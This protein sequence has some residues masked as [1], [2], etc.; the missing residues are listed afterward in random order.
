MKKIVLL[1]CIIGLRAFAQYSTPC[2]DYRVP[3]ILTDLGVVQSL[4]LTNWPIYT[5]TVAKAA[6]AVTTNDTRQLDFTGADILI[7]DATK[8]NHPVTKSQ[9]DANSGTTNATGINVAFT[10]TNYTPDS[11]SVEGHLIGIDAVVSSGSG[12]PLTNHGD[13]AGFNLTN[14]GLVQAVSGEFDYV[15]IGIQLRMTN[16]E[17]A[18]ALEVVDIMLDADI[19]DA[20][21]ARFNGG[22]SNIS[23]LLDLGDATNALNTRVGVL[24]TSTNALNTR[25]GAVETATGSLN[26]AIGNL[27]NSTNA[28]NA[29]VVAPGNSTNALNTRVGKLEVSTNAMNT[30]LG[31]LE[32]S[33]NAINAVA[34][35][36]LPKTATNALSV[37]ALQITGGSPSN[38]A[39]WV[40]T[41]ASGQG[42]L[43]V[44]SRFFATSTNSYTLAGSVNAQVIYSTERFDNNNTYNE[45]TGFWSPARIGYV[46]LGA[47]VYSTNFVDTKIVDLAIMRDGDI[48][49][50]KQRHCASG[51]RRSI[52]ITVIDYCPTLTNTY[53]VRVYGEAAVSSGIT[54]NDGLTYFWGTELP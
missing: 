4:I 10:P 19:D 14:G 9:I 13:L 40:A 39:I 5:D 7:A 42:S 25:M 17:S 34:N 20:Y 48:T 43:K 26:T 2:L 18:G 53:H 44:M 6:A 47:M 38:G 54:G 16:S 23:W 29:K 45:A 28:L 33:T 24:E 30:R 52:N 41:N 3:G 15:D 37:T 22:W 12:F 32:V 50:G 1:F 46:Q 35:A 8:T 11:A 21:Y 27:N 49:I 51:T 31:S 36:A